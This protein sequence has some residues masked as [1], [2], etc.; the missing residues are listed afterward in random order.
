MRTEN[1]FLQSVQVLRELIANRHSFEASTVTTNM[2]DNGGA[3][4]KL[5]WQLSGVFEKSERQARLNALSALIG[6]QIISTTGNGGLTCGETY[7]LLDWISWE[8]HFPL[9]EPN[10]EHV[11]IRLH[12]D[13]ERWVPYLNKHLEPMTV[14]K[15]TYVQT[16]F[17]PF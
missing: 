10:A 14:P 11:L 6:R 9:I 12:N 8:E 16:N 3:I 13:P 2:R 1:G 17:A 15:G 4:R 7:A 5:N